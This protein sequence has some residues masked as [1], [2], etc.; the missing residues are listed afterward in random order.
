MTWLEKLEL[1]SKSG[2][3]FL[4]EAECYQLWVYIASMV[5]RVTEKK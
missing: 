1:A 5:K 2:G 3:V 4:G